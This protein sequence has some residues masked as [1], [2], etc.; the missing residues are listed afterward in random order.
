MGEERYSSNFLDLVSGWRSSKGKIMLKHSFIETWE[1]G[2]IP[3]TFLP[4]SLD[5]DEW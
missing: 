3:P 5:G 4:S 1:S 2:R